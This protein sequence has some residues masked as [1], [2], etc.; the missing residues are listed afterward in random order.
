MSQSVVYTDY[1]HN[2][3][4]IVGPNGVIER[5]Y[6]FLSGG[7]PVDVFL[8]DQNGSPIAIDWNEYQRGPDATGQPIDNFYPA[9]PSFWR[10]RSTPEEQNSA[11]KQGSDDDGRRGFLRCPGQGAD[12]DTHQHDGAADHHR[13]S[14]WFRGQEA[15]DDDGYHR[16][17]SGRI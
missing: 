13:E 16:D 5:I 11:P 12:V 7:Q 15:A 8:Y 14:D 6:A 4:Q 3:T 10:G 2:L 17:Q 1:D 9:E